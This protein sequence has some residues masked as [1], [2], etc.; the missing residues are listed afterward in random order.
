MNERSTSSERGYNNIWQKARNTFLLSHPCCRMCE[1]EGRVTRATV[2]DHII[3]HKGD[4]KLF[5][6][7][8]NNWQALCTKHHSAT[9]QRIENGKEIKRTGVDGWKVEE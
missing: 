8:R 7:T 9:K 6:D 1:E 2:V 5:W 3:P 4:Q